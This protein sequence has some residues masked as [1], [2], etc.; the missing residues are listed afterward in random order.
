MKANKK[1]APTNRKKEF[2]A[3]L[4]KEIRDQIDCSIK[5]LRTLNSFKKLKTKDLKTFSD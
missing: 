2:L 3:D 1:S 5:R 4:L